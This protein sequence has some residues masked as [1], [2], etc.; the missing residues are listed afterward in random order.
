MV[1]CTLHE[2]AV[3]CPLMHMVNF[4]MYVCCCPTL[5]LQSEYTVTI[6]VNNRFVTS[7]AI[8]GQ[9]YTLLHTT[10]QSPVAFFH[11]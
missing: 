7:V 8:S 1:V 2:S 11:C 10:V 3:L 6:D 4:A 5:C 9:T